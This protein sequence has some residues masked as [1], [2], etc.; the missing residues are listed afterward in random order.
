MDEFLRESVENL[1]LDGMEKDRNGAEK[2]VKLSQ[3][4][5]P[6][7][8]ANIYNPKELRD[9]GYTLSE[10]KIQPNRHTKEGKMIFAN[11]DPAT[12]NTVGRVTELPPAEFM[13]P[14]TREY[15]N[16]TDE[17]YGELRNSETTE[18]AEMG[19]QQSFFQYRIY[20]QFTS[21]E[22]EY[23]RV[24]WNTAD[25]LERVGFSFI[26]EGDFDDEGLDDKGVIG[27][28]YVMGSMI[29]RGAKTPEEAM[30][31]IGQTGAND[32]Q[33]RAA[34]DSANRAAQRNEQGMV[35]P[36]AATDEQA[37]DDPRY[38]GAV[39]TY[40]QAKGDMTP[41][42]IEALTPEE[43][44]SK[45]KM[46]ADMF[47]SNFAKMGMDLLMSSKNP[48]LEVG[49]A[50][51]Y[52]LEVDEAMPMEGADFGRNLL[53]LGTDPSSYFGGVGLLA[54]MGGKLTGKSLAKQALI[55]AHAGGK[56]GATF[57]AGYGGLYDAGMQTIEKQGGARE[58]YDPLRFGQA[59]A[60]G[61]SLGYALGAGT[62][63]APEAIKA[64]SNWF[65]KFQKKN[66]KTMS[67]AE[68]FK[69][70]P[71]PKN[72]STSID[73]RRGIKREDK[74]LGVLNESHK[75]LQVQASKE[76]PED[77]ADWMMDL[78][79]NHPKTSSMNVLNTMEKS[80]EVILK[81][82][83]T[84]KLTELD[85]M[86]FREMEDMIVQRPEEL[87][88]VVD[89]IRKKRM[90]VI[91][92]GATEADPEHA[93]PL[94]LVPHD[95]DVQA[96]DRILDNIDDLSDMAENRAL[97][98][99]EEETDLGD[100]ALAFKAELE[101]ADKALTPKDLPPREILD[102]D[103][104]WTRELKISLNHQDAGDFR[105]TIDDEI[106]SK[107][108]K[109]YK[110]HHLKWDEENN[111]PVYRVVDS[112]GK[113]HDLPE[114]DVVG[115]K[116]ELKLVENEMADLVQVSIDRDPMLAGN[117]ERAIMGQKMINP[118][119]A[120]K[121]EIIKGRRKV[122]EVRLAA[123]EGFQKTAGKDTFRGRELGF[124]ITMLKDEL[125]KRKKK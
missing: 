77:I 61:G 66:A 104:D 18:D 101:A 70:V 38:R 93:A 17:L 68:E 100:R 2:E 29:M 3:G 62:T 5:T 67:A 44:L 51:M 94:D 59:V 26:K 37:L 75:K 65:G 55:K 22:A 57:G 86:K 120:K 1:A 112:E 28:Q 108:G 78:L 121:P 95:P 23:N 19:L 102:T 36:V 118:N 74:M 40:L 110:V 42:G 103:T 15:V 30:R 33:L 60:I 48:D 109:E 27:L 99:L 90:K 11:G 14:T 106:V 32:E 76:V 113:K 20:E 122:L 115:G 43:I 35:D 91:E 49:N 46:I 6:S 10:P 89:H 116:P 56:F 25:R 96:A 87:V 47:K 58:E 71:I 54:R 7:I 84:H 24:A 34:W 82:P 16:R 41:E 125:A 21:N 80:I 98:K 53:G 81:D 12:E 117:L 111:R 123:Y 39:Q 72:I 124:F 63:I 97:T 119:Y 79:T 64:T 88:K 92:G 8:D 114:S 105:F 4:Q 45:G 83:E 31:N 107:S 69:D 9:N 73:V 85:I 50:L 52:L 13:L